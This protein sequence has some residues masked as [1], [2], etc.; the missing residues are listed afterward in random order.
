[1]LWGEASSYGAVG[2]AHLTVHMGK[3]MLVK[4]NE[5]QCVL[6]LACLRWKCLAVS[7]FEFL[8]PSCP[9][10][11]K[12]GHAWEPSGVMWWVLFQF[13]AKENWR[14]VKHYAKSLAL[15]EEIGCLVTFTWK[16]D[17]SSCCNLQLQGGDYHILDLVN[18]RAVWRP[19]V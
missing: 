12:L 4:G 15:Q 3:L 16:L 2:R 9:G 19:R 11:V 14:G 10:W 13:Q 18:N 5:L 7:S 8:S 6:H 1:M 17:S